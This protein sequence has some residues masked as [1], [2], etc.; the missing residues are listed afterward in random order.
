MKQKNKTLLLVS[1]L[2]YIQISLSVILIALLYSFNNKNFD[3]AY[4]QC[5]R[6]IKQQLADENTVSPEIHVKI[7]GRY[8][9]TQAR[10]LIES[11]GYR[12]KNADWNSNGTTKNYLIDYPDKNK[13]ENVYCA[14]KNIAGVKDVLF[15]QGAQI[16]SL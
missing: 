10:Y 3:P 7:D 5:T 8:S 6:E 9:F 16:S 2:V 11:S 14:L 15:L 13:P 1:L 4:M 12:V